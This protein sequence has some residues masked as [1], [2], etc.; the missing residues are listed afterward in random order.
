MDYDIAK[1]IPVGQL[2]DGDLKDPEK[3]QEEIKETPS[4][5]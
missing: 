1:H 3:E 4:K 2:P 5:K